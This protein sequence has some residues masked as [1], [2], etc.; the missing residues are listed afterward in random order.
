LIFRKN[1]LSKCP[2]F[3]DLLSAHRLV[4]P[5]IYSYSALLRAIRF[6]VRIFLDYFHTVTFNVERQNHTVIYQPVN[7]S[8]GDHRVF[9]DLLPFRKKQITGNHQTAAFVGID[10]Q[11]K[12]HLH[13]LTAL[14]HVSDAIDDDR[15]M[16]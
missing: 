3:N 13:L 14:L 4:L 16:A 7:G 5:K 6:F 10:Q 11:C 9:K 12:E 8:S 2:T 15:I 1:S